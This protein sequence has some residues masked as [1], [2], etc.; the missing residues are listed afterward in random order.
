MFS[1]YALWIQEQCLLEVTKEKKLFEAQKTSAQK[2]TKNCIFTKRS[3]L[4]RKEAFLKQKNIGSINHQNL[5]FFQRGQ[6][7]VFVKKWRFFNLQFLCKI[8]QEKVFFEGLEGKEAF[9]DQKNIRS[10]K[11]PI[12][13]F[14]QRGQSMVFVKKWRFFNVQFLC[15]MDSEAVSFGGSERKEA[16]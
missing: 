8:S 6:F 2:T 3:E 1:F 15:I 10:K 12:F 14:F 4:E 7:M 11:L 5:H 9:L 13:A 16:F